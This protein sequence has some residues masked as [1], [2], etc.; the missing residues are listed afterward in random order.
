MIGAII[1]D[2]I[3]S[4]WE[5]SFKYE[6]NFPLF[7]EKCRFT[8]DTVLTCATADA[9]MHPSLKPF[10]RRFAEKDQQWVLGW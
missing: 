4:R 1:G 3:G 7:A 6:P 5:M 9:L 8:D 10:K 2:I